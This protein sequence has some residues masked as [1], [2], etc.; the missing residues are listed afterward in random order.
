LS[1]SPGM[2]LGCFGC[3]CDSENGAATLGEEMNWKRIYSAAVALSLL[4]LLLLFVRIFPD[5]GRTSVAAPDDEALIA[6]K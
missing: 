4:G 3:C 1:V 6:R 2:P 5:S